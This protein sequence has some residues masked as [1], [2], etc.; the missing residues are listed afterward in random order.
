MV[1]V[2]AGVARKHPQ[3]AYAG[4]KKSLQ[5]EWAFV[6]RVTPEVGEAFGPVEEALREIFFPALFE[7]LRKGVS[8]REITRL[9]VNQAG[10]ALPDPIQTAPE[11][12][13]ASCVI[14][15]YLVAALRGQVVFRTA[16]HSACLWGGRVAVQHQGEKH[17]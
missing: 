8:Y 1:K 6:K 15:G 13:T 5:Q 10:L 11:N 16:D 4:L 3:S 9:P 2:M 12:W 14:T 7:G 17:A